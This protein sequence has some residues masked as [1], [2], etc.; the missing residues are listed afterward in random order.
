MKPTASGVDE[1]KRLVAKAAEEDKAGN[2]EACRNT[3]MQAKEK[4]GALP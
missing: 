1:A 3:I 2:A 4:A